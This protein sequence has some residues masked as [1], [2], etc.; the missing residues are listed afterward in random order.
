MCLIGIGKPRKQFS[1]S[2]SFLSSIVSKSDDDLDP[3]NPKNNLA[4]CNSDSIPLNYYSNKN[5]LLN[6]GPDYLIQPQDICFYISI[7]KEEN[8]NWKAAKLKICNR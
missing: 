8:Y 2:S 6:P 4:S 3:N 7:V 5:I 1:N